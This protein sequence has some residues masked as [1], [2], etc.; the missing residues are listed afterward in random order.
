MCS[1]CILFLS[2]MLM[3]CVSIGWSKVGGFTP[4]LDQMYS[5]I[6]IFLTVNAICQIIASLN[7]M[8]PSNKLNT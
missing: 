2:E 1:M 3:W 4:Y 5:L 8:K 7:I 6:N